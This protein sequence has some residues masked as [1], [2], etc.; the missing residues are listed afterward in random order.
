MD[1]QVLEPEIKVRTNPVDDVLRVV[2][3]DE[4]SVCLVSVLV[5]DPLHLQRVLDPGLLIRA[6]RQRRPP[7]AG[8]V[9][10]IEVVVV[11]HFDFDR[12]PDIRSVPACRCSALLHV[13]QERLVQFGWLAA[14]ADEAVA[15]LTGELGGKGPGRRH[16]DRHL[17]LWAVV[18]RRAGGPVVVALEVDALLSP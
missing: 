18:D 4:A 15:D 7:A 13:R 16:E 9:G 11:R 14:R 12:A 3:D 8:V 2:P 1:D 10:V 5:R 6:E 17:F